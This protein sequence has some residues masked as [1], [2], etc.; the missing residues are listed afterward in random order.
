MLAKDQDMYFDYVALPV[1]VFHFKT[2]HKENDEFCGCFCNPAQWN[3]LIDEDSGKW[4]F[5]SS[6]A[7][8]VN[9]WFGG[10]RAITRLMRADRS[11]LSSELAVQQASDLFI[12]RFNF[13]LD[14]MIMWRNMA[15]IAQLEASG[16]APYSIPHHALLGEGHRVSHHG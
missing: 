13:F 5:N 3:E 9:V 12:D 4:T 7:E 15:L 16:A 6:A 1:D 14:E 8:Q 2:K 10:F 11:V